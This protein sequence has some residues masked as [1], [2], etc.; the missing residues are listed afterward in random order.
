MKRHTIKQPIDISIIQ[1]FVLNERNIDKILQHT[2]KGNG[3]VSGKSK[4][5]IKKAEAD[6]AVT[7]PT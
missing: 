1:D 3:Q 7:T 4:K 2:I 6:V 5:E